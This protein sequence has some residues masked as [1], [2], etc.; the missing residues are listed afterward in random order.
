MWYHRL[1]LNIK[2]LRTN[3]TT[4]LKARRIQESTWIAV[5][6]LK[7]YA[8]FE[9]SPQ[10]TSGLYLSKHVDFFQQAAEYVPALHLVRERYR[11]VLFRP[12]FNNEIPKGQ[13]NDKFTYR[14]KLILVTRI[15]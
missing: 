11:R 3:R 6:I 9:Y 13:N 15:L 7:N 10:N 14:A 4:M 1:A 8:T 12:V 2:T 5:V